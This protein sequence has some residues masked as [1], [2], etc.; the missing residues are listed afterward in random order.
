MPRLL[1]LCLAAAFLGAQEPEPPT[2]RVGVG[3]FT[4][5]YTDASG[6]WKGWSLSG[7]WFRD[8]HGP[9]VFS[10]VGT[11]RP[12]GTGTL[13]TVGKEH[14]FGESSSVWASLG[15]G[16]G[17]EFTPSFRSDVDLNLGLSGGWAL[18]LEGAWT[19]FPGGSSTAL[20]QAGPAW[21]GENWS[22]SARVQQV[23]YLPGQY[24]DTGYLTDLRWGTNNLRR[25]H[26][27]RVAWGQGVI[28]AMQVGGSVSA[29]LFSGGSGS[30]SGGGWGHGPGSGAGGTGTST[31]TSTTASV[32]Y[33]RLNELLISISSHVPI[34]KR[35]AIRA[36]L[37]W[38]QRESQYKLWS[39]N[40]Q[41]LITF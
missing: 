22:A 8:E 23:R 39:V 37:A 21:L 20:F 38:G 3:A 1:V 36:N 32:S 25:W 13:F 15:G 10:A 24:T 40:L 14:A 17:A 27:L 26:S 12:E 34:S 6:T 30:G 35:F 18:G 7:E 11:S 9:W 33:P 41:T 28:D 16:T 5:R 19:R 29:G 2:A 31:T 4:D